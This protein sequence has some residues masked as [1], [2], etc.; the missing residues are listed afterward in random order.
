MTNDLTQDCLG[1]TQEVCGLGWKNEQF[2]REIKQLTGI[3]RNQCRKARI[4]RNH[5][6]RLRHA[7]LNSSHRPSPSTTKTVYCIKH[8]L[9]DGLPCVSNSKIQRSQ[10]PLRKSYY[11]EFEVIWKHH[12][13]TI[14]KRKRWRVPVITMP[15]LM[16]LTV[17]FHQL[18]H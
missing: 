15:D 12:V 13:L 18:R 5:L 14:G 11:K 10:C 3:E 2:H 6:H 16:T 7:G 9:L 4:Q 17:L 8:G 1:A